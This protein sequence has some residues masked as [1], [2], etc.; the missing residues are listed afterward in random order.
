[1]LPAYEAL[2][3]EL[4]ISDRFRFLGFTPDVRPAVV[5]FDILT[6]PS[7]QEPFGRSIIEAMALG[8]PVVATRVGGVPEIIT[9]GE[10][11]LL[12]PPD[13]PAALAE[14]IDRLL[15]DA[16][17]RARLGAAGRD[18]VHECFDVAKLGQ[19]I[20]DIIVDTIDAR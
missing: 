3:A 7:L 16:A 8:A 20:Q 2:V 15:G 1:M 4:G 12:V 18:R 5:D 11:G 19:R 10:H 17:L 6:L 14:A 13:D 9:D